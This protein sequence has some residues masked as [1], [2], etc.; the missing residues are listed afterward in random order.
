MAEIMILPTQCVLVF[1]STRDTKHGPER[2]F[3][4]RAPGVGMSRYAQERWREPVPDNTSQTASLACPSLAG[5]AAS[6][7]ASRNSIG[8]DYG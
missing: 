5:R 7:E 4:M 6:R 2:G 1:P 3:Q 8:L